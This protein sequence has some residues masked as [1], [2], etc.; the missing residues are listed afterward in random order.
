MPS[1]RRHQARTWL[2]GLCAAKTQSDHFSKHTAQKLECT[3]RQKQ[4]PQKEI[5]EW[6]VS[7]LSGWRHFDARLMSISGTHVAE[8]K[9]LPKPDNYPLVSS[10]SAWST[11]REGERAREGVCYPLLSPHNVACGLTIKKKKWPDSCL[12]CEWPL[13]GPQFEHSSHPHTV[14]HSPTTLL[15]PEP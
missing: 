13:L 3:R 6:S 1:L 11:G 15:Y 7:C 2:V 8:E 9:W 5:S 12:M 10:K 4:L 14:P